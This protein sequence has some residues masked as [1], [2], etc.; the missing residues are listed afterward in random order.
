[1]SVRYGWSSRPPRNWMTTSRDAWMLTGRPVITI[2]VS[3]SGI[4]DGAISGSSSDTGR[5]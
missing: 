5:E 1:M 4:N 2:N 3:R